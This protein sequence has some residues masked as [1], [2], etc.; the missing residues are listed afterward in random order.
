MALVVAVVVRLD[1][2]VVAVAIQDRSA[3][4][5]LPVVRVATH[6]SPMVL[7]SLGMVVAAVLVRHLILMVSARTG[8][9][10]QHPVVLRT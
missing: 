4:L 7:A 9:R 6:V 8:H 1:W 10:G 5:A 3:K 2:V